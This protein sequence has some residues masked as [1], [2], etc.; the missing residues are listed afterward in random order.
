[1]ATDLEDVRRDVA[2]LTRRMD[3]L[4]S[5]VKAIA[6]L[7]STVA[8]LGVRVD[9]VVAGIGGVRDSLGHVRTALEDR[10][11]SATEERRS[12]RVALIGLTATIAAALIAAITTIVVAGAPG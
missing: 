11:K 12:L 4:E 6:P 8:E 5:D 3:D 9:N 1:M 7:V 2:V 10:D